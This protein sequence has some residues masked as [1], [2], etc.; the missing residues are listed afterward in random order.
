MADECLP[1]PSGYHLSPRLFS[2]SGWGQ[3][4]PFGA[5]MLELGGGGVFSLAEQT[6]NLHVAFQAG[7]WP[8]PTLAMQ[9]EPWSPRI[10][11]KKLCCRLEK[12]SKQRQ[13]GFSFQAHPEHQVPPVL[14][15]GS[16]EADMRDPDGFSLPSLRLTVNTALDLSEG[17][18]KSRLLCLTRLAAL[19]LLLCSAPALQCQ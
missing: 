15:S 8:L 10:F 1:S 11:Q 3:T 13:T 17:F 4:G 16:L 14:A 2:G 19:L 6:L 9:G 5:Y 7:A 18:T 12:A